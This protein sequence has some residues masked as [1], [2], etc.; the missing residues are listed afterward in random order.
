MIISSLKHERNFMLIGYGMTAMFFFLGIFW[1]KYILISAI[2]ALAGCFLHRLA[3]IEYLKKNALCF[4]WARI[5]NTSLKGEVDLVVIARQLVYNPHFSRDTV[6]AINF[7][8]SINSIMSNI[9]ITYPEDIR[10]QAIQIS[11]L[12]TT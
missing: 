4:S 6:D 9:P 8:Q 7:Q 11:N 3:Q 10:I 5:Y 2:L 12:K 1:I